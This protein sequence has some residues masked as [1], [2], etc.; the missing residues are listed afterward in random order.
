MSGPSYA[1]RRDGLNV[2]LTDCPTR[3]YSGKKTHA[4]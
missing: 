4:Q 3:N 2:Q 1:R